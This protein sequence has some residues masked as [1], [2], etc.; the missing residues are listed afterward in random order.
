MRRIFRPMPLAM[1]LAL[2]CSACTRINY[3]PATGHVSYWAVMQRKAFVAERQ[4][5]G[6]LT[7]RYNTDSDAVTELMREVR[8]LAELAA[9]AGAK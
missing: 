1:L 3:N 9:K 5:D 4:P 6:V 2:A 7:I 8:A